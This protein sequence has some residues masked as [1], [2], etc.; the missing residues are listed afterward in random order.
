[1]M[2]RG[3]YVE[4]R[5]KFADSDDTIVTFWRCGGPSSEPRSY[6]VGFVFRKAADGGWN[7]FAWPLIEK[8]ETPVTPAPS[9]APPDRYTAPDPKP[10]GS[11][12]PPPPVVRAR[13]VAI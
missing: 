10:D 1:M 12:A 13:G 4:R 5:L 3:C 9:K 7:R 11:T 2:L 6:N 8:H